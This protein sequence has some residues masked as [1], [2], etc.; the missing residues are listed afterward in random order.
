[1]GLTV[2]IKYVRFLVKP[3]TFTRLSKYIFLII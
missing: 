1:L 3:R 2:Y